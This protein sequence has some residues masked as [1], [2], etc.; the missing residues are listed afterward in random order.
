MC[1]AVSTQLFKLN[2]QIKCDQAINNME[3]EMFANE[4][5]L[6]E[7]ANAKCFAITF[8]VGTQLTTDIASKIKSFSDYIQKNEQV[9]GEDCQSTLKQIDLAVDFMNNS[10]KSENFESFKDINSI[11]RDK[12]VISATSDKSLFE[13]FVSIQYASVASKKITFILDEN[14][15]YLKQ[16]F[17]SVFHISEVIETVSSITKTSQYCTQ[18]IFDS[19]DYL[20]A[21]NV[22]AT[23]F[24]E[25]TAPWKIRSCWIQDTLQSKFFSCFQSLLSNSRPLNDV[26][27]TELNNILVKSKQYD[28]KVFQSEDKNATFLVGLTKK[29]ID[30][31]LGVLVNF[32][33]TPKEVV[34]LVQTTDKT[35][36]ISL[37]SE[38]VSLAYDVTDKL[39]VE[40]VWINSNGLLNP[41]VPFTFGRGDDK[42]IYGSKLGI[43][44]MLNPQK[45]HLSGNLRPTY[46]AALTVPGKYNFQTT[47][48]VKPTPYIVD[49][50]ANDVID[51]ELRN[52]IDVSQVH[53]FK[54][55]CVTFG[56]IFGN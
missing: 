43:A 56:Q 34:S 8:N 39:D 27:K 3:H 33:R 28:C 50:S 49:A 47:S 36:S 46:S 1:A 20:S 2:N 38:S 6:H 55:V 21:F 41:E 18:I 31:N 11:K 44:Q 32:F 25:T 23:A 13:I 37:W 54:T 16:V 52:L 42:R 29:H 26:Q 9:N 24:N 40:N 30:S 14:R 22:L 45:K 4:K 51:V 5:I 10:T 35:N 17:Q 48:R 15:E 53:V 7:P 19:A 12:V